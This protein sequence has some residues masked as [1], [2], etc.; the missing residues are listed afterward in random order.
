MKGIFLF[1]IDTQ[2]DFML[3]DG[4]LYVPGAER[5][6]P[7]L[8]RLF[9]F[10]KAHGVTIISTADAHAPE[11]LE[12]VNYP[13]HCLRG[14]EGQRKV[15]ESLL[16]HPLILENKPANRNFAELVRKHQQIIVEKQEF[17]VFSNPVIE[18]LLRVLPPHAVIFG[19]PADH[20]VKPAALGLRRLGL[21]AAVVQNA[22]LPLEPREAAKSEAA[23]RSAGVEFI[24]LEVLVGAITEG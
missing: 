7:K 24:T 20:A 15:N 14:T 19:V 9:D 16:L 6:L 4:K 3:S 2:R 23:M 12:F 10:A 1:D 5:L 11:D 13:P 17:D 8:R 22:T 18:K 21:K